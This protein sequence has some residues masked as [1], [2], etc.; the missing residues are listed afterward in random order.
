MGDKALTLELVTPEKV[1]WSAPAAT[2]VRRAIT[3]V[4]WP[5]ASAVEPRSGSNSTP[6]TSPG[7]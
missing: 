1:A 6:N 2:K 4:T 3:S 5:I 7:R